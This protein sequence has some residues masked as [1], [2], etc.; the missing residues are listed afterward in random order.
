MLIF[1]VPPEL[2]YM[3]V[4]LSVVPAFLGKRFATRNFHTAHTPPLYVS[5]KCKI[6]LHE[7]GQLKN[8]GMA[9]ILLMKIHPF[10]FGMN[11]R[12]RN[13]YHAL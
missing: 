3:S 9:P 8:L 7:C 2:Q 13:G 10:S 4:F 6:V 1:H 11:T 12:K 5:L